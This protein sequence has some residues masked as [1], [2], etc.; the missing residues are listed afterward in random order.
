MKTLHPT[1]Q[2]PPGLTAEPAELELWDR[3]TVLKFFG[4][5]KPLHVSTLYRGVHSGRYPPPMYVSDNVVRWI[6]AECRAARRRMFSERGE[7]K[8]P[9]RPG[10]PR[11]RITP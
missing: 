11:R 2:T 3:A 1:D 8:P 5:T 6:G 4:G 7:P 10:R 9:P